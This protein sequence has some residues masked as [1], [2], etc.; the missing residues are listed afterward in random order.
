MDPSPSRVPSYV[1]IINIASSCH[2]SATIDFP[3]DA[4]SSTTPTLPRD[5]HSEMC[6]A[7]TVR[8][9]WECWSQE[10][11]IGYTSIYLGASSLC[12]FPSPAAVMQDSGPPPRIGLPPLNYA[13]AGL[14]SFIQETLNFARTLHWSRQE[15]HAQLSGPPFVPD[16]GKPQLGLHGRL[17][18]LHLARFPTPAR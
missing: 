6:R 9:Q 7:S 17:W 10:S 13:L 5:W 3:R 12:P 8:G 15:P 1:S 11:N 16:H 18:L 4:I 14:L 2:Y